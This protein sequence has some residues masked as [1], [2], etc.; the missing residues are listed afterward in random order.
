M[1]IV[2]LCNVSL[3]NHAHKGSNYIK[4]VIEMPQLNIRLNN[5]EMGKLRELADHDFRTMSG[6]L[7]MLI[8]REFDKQKEKGGGQ[9]NA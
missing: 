8:L 5:E 2:Y 9:H 3:F 6:Y 1:C 4:E 7:K